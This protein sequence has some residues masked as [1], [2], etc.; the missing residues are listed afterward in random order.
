MAYC[1]IENLLG[2]SNLYCV[3]AIGYLTHS[4][5]LFFTL[6]IYTYARGTGISG[7]HRANEGRRNQRMRYIITGETAYLEPSNHAVASIDEEVKTLAQL[8][9]GDPALG[10]LIPASKN[11]RDT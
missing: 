4:A 9:Q 10:A 2:E 11:R 7:N 6:T 8:T 3:P 5:L 1:P